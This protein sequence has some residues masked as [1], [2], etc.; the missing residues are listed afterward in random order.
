MSA[1]SALRETA[2]HIARCRTKVMLAPGRADVS[3]DGCTALDAIADAIAALAKA[4]P[5]I[6][7]HADTLEGIVDQIHDLASDVTGRV[8]RAMEEP[9]Y[10]PHA[11]AAAQDRRNAA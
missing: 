5:E 10:C 3:L 6:E 11:E 2:A 1:T 4:R 9:P 8:L 7:A